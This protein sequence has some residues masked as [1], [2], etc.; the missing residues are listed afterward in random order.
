VRSPS[1]RTRGEEGVARPRVVALLAAWQAE[2]FVERALASLAAQTWPDLEI[3]ISIDNS[4]DRT[5]EICRSFAARHGR[6]EVV[7][8]DERLGWIGNVNWLLR[9]ADADYLFIAGADDLIAPTYVE[10]L[11]AA[12]EARPS[13]VL[14]FSDIEFVHQDGRI[15]ILRYRALDGVASR[16]VRAA[17]VIRRTRGWW[18]PYRGLVRTVAARRI[19]GLR[20]HRAGEFA[21]DWPWHLELA[22]IGGFVRVAETLCRKHGR[23]ASVSGGWDYSLRNWFAVSLSCAAGI[24]RSQLGFVAKAALVAFLWA[25]YVRNVIARLAAGLRRAAPGSSAAV[26]GGSE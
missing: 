4:T 21:A 22:M 15:E 20:R 10:R 6:T 19:G 11:F 25:I 7:V 12:I 8:Q 17:Q 9:R 26:A 5:A 14:A 13:A 24:R 23:A 1:P 3:L 18:L 2:A 16:F